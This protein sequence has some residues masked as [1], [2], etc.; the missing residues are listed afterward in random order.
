MADV[1]RFAVCREHAD[2]ALEMMTGKNAQI[3]GVR[4]DPMYRCHCGAQA[5]WFLIELDMNRAIAD[6]VKSW[7]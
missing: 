7:E 5:R 4:Q 1:E 3:R 6:Y 2:E